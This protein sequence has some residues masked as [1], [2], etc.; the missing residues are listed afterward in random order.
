MSEHSKAPWVAVYYD[1]SVAE[2]PGWNVDCNPPDVLS[3]ATVHR[4]YGRP[5]EDAAN[6]RLIAAAPEL[7]ST[8]QALCDAV[9]VERKA[10]DTYIQASSDV[11]DDTFDTA[12]DA[13]QDAC[14]TTIICEVAARAAIAKARGAA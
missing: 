8:L 6:A 7:L 11:N 9:Q 3:V 1:E 13:Y 10:Q 2:Q 12:A 4:G 5:G 14:A